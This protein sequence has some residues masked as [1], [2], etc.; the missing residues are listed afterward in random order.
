MK[1]LIRLKNNIWHVVDGKVVEGPH[2]KISG[3]VS[4]I[5]GDVSG[6]SSNVDLIPMSER[7]K[8]PYISD[9]VQD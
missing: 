4:G 7:A 6:I 8:K 9:W 5:R 3:N 1:P 2:D